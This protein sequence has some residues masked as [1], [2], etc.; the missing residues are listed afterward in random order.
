MNEINVERNEKDHRFE[1]RVGD[2]MARIDYSRSGK[3]LTLIHTEVPKAFE[4]KGVGGKLAQTAL[5]YA[6]A[7]SLKVVPSCP[8]VAT[9]IR[10]HPAFM[11]LVAPD[12]KFT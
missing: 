7:E 10:R 12:F 2:E 4:G 8:F 11:E 9:Y 1:V 3:T 5:E 6:R